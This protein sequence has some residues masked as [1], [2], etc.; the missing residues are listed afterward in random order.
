V[1]VKPQQKQQLMMLAWPSISMQDKDLYAAYL[2]TMVL[3]DGTGSRLFWNIFQK[4]LAE[5]ASA[6]LSPMDNTGMMLTFL[7]TTPDHAPAVLELAR[8]EL[9]GMQEDGV[10]EDELRRAKDKLVSGTVLDGES[11]YGRMRDLAYTWVAEDR[12]RTIEDE[13]AQI[14]AVTLEDVRRVLDRFPL[15]ER[16]VLLTYGP[17]EAAAFGLDPEAQSAASDEDEDND[18]AEGA[19]EG[20]QA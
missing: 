11:A 4:G 14:E 15:T 19:G 7:S 17:L 12:L 9:R 18:E 16:H 20:G 6:S 1:I 5:T 13:M 10:Q 8:A 2:A 3:G